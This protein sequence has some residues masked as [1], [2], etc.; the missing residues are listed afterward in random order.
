M[1]TS[2]ITP[3]QESEMR[4]TAWRENITAEISENQTTA[5]SA[6]V[7]AVRGSID[8]TLIEMAFRYR[9]QA[10]HLQKI[11]D[12]ALRVRELKSNGK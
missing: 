10:V 12:D 4:F 3:E 6:A 2:K 1:D 7:A 9:S 11:L 5:D 8:W